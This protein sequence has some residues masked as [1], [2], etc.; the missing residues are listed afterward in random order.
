MKLIDLYWEYWECIHRTRS[1]FCLLLD[2]FSNFSNETFSLSWSI[3][4]AFQ[5][6]YENN[7]SAI[8]LSA[9]AK[10][11]NYNVFHL[12]VYSFIESTL[13]S[14]FYCC[15]VV[16]FFHR[17]VLLY[18]FKMQAELWTRDGKSTEEE[19]K[20]MEREKGEIN[21]MN[22]SDPHNICNKCIVC[23]LEEMQ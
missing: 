5:I 18:S 11:S 4:S 13:S 9:N 12:F 3:Y 14:Y 8:P 23:T 21:R 10:I 1:H 20:K 17:N 2:W 7:S 19:C 6:D 15:L 16:G 22:D